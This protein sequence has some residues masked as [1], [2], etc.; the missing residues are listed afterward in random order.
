MISTPISHFGSRGAPGGN[1]VNGVDAHAVFMSALPLK[2]DLLAG[3]IGKRSFHYVDIPVHGNIG[4]LL[5]MHGTMAFYTKKKLR[6]RIIAPAMAYRSE[7]IRKG[8]VVV[9]HGGGNFGDLYWDCGSQRLREQ[10][11]QAMPENRIIVLPQTL[12]FSSLEERKRSARLFRGHPD[13]HLC[14]RDEP[15]RQVA[16]EFSDHVYLLPDMAHQLYPVKT[17]RNAASAGTLLISRTDEEK[18]DS[19][20]A[21]AGKVSRTSD[22]PELVGT[23]ERHVDRFRRAMR[24]LCRAGLGWSADRILSNAWMAYSGMLIADAIDLFAPHERIV[25][26]RLH[27]HI[28][29]CLMNKP[30]TVLDNFYGKNS[31]YV[32]AWTADS[33]L[34]TLHKPMKYPGMEAT[35]AKSVSCGCEE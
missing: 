32:N 15:S 24:F 4:D 19:A 16:M 17:P 2:H 28:L 10:V 23:R 3:L 29:A 20:P 6:P 33:A 25:T 27:G 14:V 21:V 7:W 31:S 22:W 11:V 30:S 26:D 18:M 35:A 9:F 12:H 8:E 5:I 34:V 1:A 13:V